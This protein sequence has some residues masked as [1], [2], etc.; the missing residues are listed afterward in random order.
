VA[1]AA[2][3][4][5]AC[6]LP[7]GWEVH[8]AK[9]KGQPKDAKS[10][11][12]KHSGLGKPPPRRFFGVQ[13]YEPLTV[14]ELRALKKARVGV[15]R[16]GFSWPAVEPMPGARYWDYLDFRV[17]LAAQFGIRIL[18]ILIGSA[19][20]YA[21]SPL[22]PPVRSGAASAGWAAFVADAVRRY[23]PGGAFW[24]AHPNL[25]PLP[26]TEWQVWNEPS[27][28]NWW[29]GGPNGVEYGRLV[30]QT[31]A[32]VRQVDPN[33]RV[34]LAGL[35]AHR[36]DPSG[37]PIRTFLDG[38]YATPGAKRSFDAV[39]LHPYTSKPGRVLEL[40]QELRKLVRKHGD[41]NKELLIT[42]VGWATGGS[43][44]RA[45]ITTPKGQAR[46]LRKVYRLLLSHR[47]ELRLEGIVWHVIRDYADPHSD[48]WAYSMGLFT[49]ARDPKPA[50]RALARI[51]GGKPK[52]LKEP[53]GQPTPPPV[54]IHPPGQ[55]SPPPPC[56]LKVLC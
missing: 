18:P 53:P 4:T 1:A 52:G 56:F 10:K 15:H 36:N 33:A 34:I 3:L 29:A 47:R 20:Q 25:R 24:Q 22:E 5:G 38:V 41:R 2:I 28:G 30:V 9:Q 43:G 21:S 39:A 17:A 46:R 31:S 7:G 55:G 49:A 14:G 50:W 37:V 44:E 19:G 11:P 16:T 6:S 32:A 12:V 8:A 54:S 51:T 40:A 42:E 26:V 48:W 23:G 27:S 13:S 45:L 35:L